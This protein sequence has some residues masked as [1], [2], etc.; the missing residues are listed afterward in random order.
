MEECTME[1][2]FE[3][4]DEQLRDVSGGTGS[5]TFSFTNSASGTTAAVSGTFT[6][7]TTASTAS[8]SGSFSS[9]ST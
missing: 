7:S 2:I 9:S 5:A 4:S 8:Q 1:I 6:Q 3:L